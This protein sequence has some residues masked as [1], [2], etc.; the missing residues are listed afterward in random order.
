MPIRVPRP[1][2]PWEPSFQLLLWGMKRALISPIINNL[3]GCVTYTEL[4]SSKAFPNKLLKYIYTMDDVLCIRFHLTTT[5]LFFS[6]PQ[7]LAH[8]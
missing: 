4:S 1:V 6:A 8:A 7:L 2:T 3:K 5:S